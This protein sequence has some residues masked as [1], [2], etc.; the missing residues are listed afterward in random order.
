MIGKYSITTG[1]S[2]AVHWTFWNNNDDTLGEKFYLASFPDSLSTNKL[3]K[4]FL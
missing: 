4:I 3:K 1:I 2:F